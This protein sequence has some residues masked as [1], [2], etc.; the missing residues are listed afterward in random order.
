MPLSREQIE[1]AKWKYVAEADACELCQ[2]HVGE[3]FETSEIWDV[4][5]YAMPLFDNVIE[6]NIHPNCRCQLILI[7]EER[8]KD[9]E[10]L[11]RMTTAV[12]SYILIEEGHMKEKL[13]SD[14]IKIQNEFTNYYCKSPVSCDQG[15]F[16]FNSWINDLGLDTSKPYGKSMEAF[17]WAKDMITKYKEDEDATYWKVLFA[18][19]ITSMNYNVYTEKEIEASVQTV[20][21]NLG[22]VPSLNHWED[23]RELFAAGG[24][25]YVA[26]NYEDG[27]C[28]A[29]LKVPNAF[30]CPMCGKDKTLNSLI[31]NKK[32]VNVSL[33]ASCTLG[34]GP[35]GK[36][37]M[38]LVFDPPT[39][40]TVDTL[41]G[42]PLAKIFP[43]EKLV[44]EA[45][46]RKR[47][48][49]RMEIKIVGLEA[50]PV[51]PDGNGQCPDGMIFDS[52][53]G[54][55]VSVKPEGIDCPDGQ[56]WNS[57]SGTCVSD[58][59]APPEGTEIPL[60]TP[61][62]LDNSTAAI[63]AMT[64]DE[65]VKAIADIAAKI[66]NYYDDGIDTTEIEPLHAQMIAYQDALQA[67]IMQ[68]ALAPEKYKDALEE[69]TCPDGMMW[70]DKS[71]MCIQV[72]KPDGTQPPITPAATPSDPV[73][74]AKTPSTGG[75]PQV[76][77][78][79][80][81]APL[82]ASTM[83][84]PPPHGEQI[85]PPPAAGVSTAGGKPCPDGQV[86]NAATGNCEAPP[87]PP[88]TAQ[89]PVV[90]DPPGL[91]GSPEERASLKLTVAELELVNFQ[92]D[93]K[94]QSAEAQ[95]A[96]L[97]QQ[98]KQLVVDKINL[99]AALNSSNTEGARLQATIDKRDKS[100]IE[101]AQELALREVELNAAMAKHLKALEDLKAH[102]EVTAISRDNYKNI[103]E[104]AKDEY[105]KLDDLY[106]GQLEANL[107]ITKKLTKA[108]ED[109]L[110]LTQ[111]KR[112]LETIIK[113]AKRLNKIVVQM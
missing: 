87:A 109:I 60:G 25:K 110:E 57:V 100:L 15:T 8:L 113:K 91:T 83:T 88:A 32:I 62:A 66:D 97:N 112:S 90:T 37:C 80:D 54:Y 1:P 48:K 9:V 61:A 58:E 73:G 24:V 13:H 31:E 6:P 78:P 49:R 39:L 111:E 7:E 36:T 94:F 75:T 104:K 47:G 89:T 33:E 5:P 86:Y 95:V 71:G 76:T 4:F 105:T 107:A 30:I 96:Y 23:T 56:H 51:M 3:T 101:K 42:I 70:D 85:T 45:V 81:T 40:L 93:Q 19:P 106:T 26:A 65:L 20:T 82:P 12:P 92:T 11:K 50:D 29:I 53:L 68:K 59:E 14:F 28:E 34:T 43:L 27:A 67:L 69:F 10:L 77:D 35:D 108:N 41:P 63:E 2:I 17:V 98:M 79:P 103:A 46:G 16:E 84:G 38:G 55:C 102:S 74:D 22:G 99:Q 44:R 52:S 64:E 18:F 72:P 21:T